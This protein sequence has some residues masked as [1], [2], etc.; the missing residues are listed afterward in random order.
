MQY[1]PK[2]GGTPKKNEVIFISPTGEEIVSRRQLEQYLKANPGGP[3]VSEFD[4]GTG[5]TP[6]RSARISEKAKAAPPPEIEPLKKRSRKSSASKKDTKEKEAAPEGAEE[7]KE[8]HMQDAE[9]TEKE[10]ANV[11]V[12][13]D[14]LEQSQDDNSVL[15]TSTKTEGTPKEGKTGQEVN[16]S[17]DG[18]ESKKTAEAKLKILKETAGEKEAEVSE[19]APTENAKLKGAND[20]EKAQQ[21]QV[22]AEKED[23]SQEPD[24]PDTVGADGKKYGAEGEGKEGDSR[25]A[26]ESEGEIKENSMKGNNDDHKADVHEKTNMVEGEFIENGSRGGNTPEV[27]P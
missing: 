16:L 6:R 23:R 22:E 17:N 14:G 15:D 2:Q 4:W 5:E 10:N 12:E 25:S 3:A 13:K 24:K 8:V 21:P 20:Q 19:V 11:E 18:E 27:K 9:K 26:L 1:F 7:T